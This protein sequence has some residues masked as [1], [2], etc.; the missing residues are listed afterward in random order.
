MKCKELYV[1]RGIVIFADAL[2]REHHVDR[3]ECLDLLVGL[4]KEQSKEQVAR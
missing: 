4:L 1:A 2:M 3:T